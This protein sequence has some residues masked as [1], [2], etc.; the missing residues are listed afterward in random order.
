MRDKKTRE[1][2]HTPVDMRTLTLTLTVSVFMALLAFFI[3]LNALSPEST[4]KQKLLR[5][6]ISNTFGFVG[7]GQA[8]DLPDE[9]GSGTDGDAEEAAAAGLRSILPDVGFQQARVGERGQMMVVTIP[10]DQFENRWPELRTR[11]GDVMVNH[12]RGGR[13]MLHI[14]ALDGPGQAGELVKIAQELADE[15]LDRDMIGVG[16][17]DRGIPSIELRFV[18][19]GG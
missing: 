4:V 14:L 17:S 18:R 13:Y 6:S 2:I 3:V 16:Y 15:G 12:N 1:G 10:R 9:D 5:A 8:Y 11:L 19:G 7:Y